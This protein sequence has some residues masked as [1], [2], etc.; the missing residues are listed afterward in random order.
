MV[1][2]AVLQTSEAEIMLGQEV[3]RLILEQLKIMN[4]HLACLT[5]ENFTTGDLEKD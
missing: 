2:D 4:L 5:D 3:Q 1:R